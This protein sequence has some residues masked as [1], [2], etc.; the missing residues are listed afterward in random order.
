[1]LLRNSSL[2]R[3]TVGQRD[4]HY[5]TVL[6]IAY[7]T[8]YPQ[9]VRSYG[10]G[11]DLSVRERHGNPIVARQPDRSNADSIPML[12]SVYSNRINT[13]HQPHGSVRMQSLIE[14]VRPRV[15]V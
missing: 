3:G 1:M 14:L 2:Y 10:N 4:T 11:D 9:E 15:L 7:A 6:F 13:V 5:D 12:I 8:V